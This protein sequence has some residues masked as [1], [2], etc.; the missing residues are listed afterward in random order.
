[1]IDTHG[2]KYVQPLFDIMSKFLAKKGIHPI[3]ITLSALVLGLMSICFVYLDWKVIA[4]FFLWSSGLLD[5]LDGTVARLT[6]RKSDLGAFLDITFDRII[7]LGL[8]IALALSD[9]RLSIMLV[10]LSC[11]IVMSLTIFLTIGNFAKKSTNKA[12]YYQAG[13]AERTEGFIFF[14]LMI[15]FP[16]VRLLIGYIFASVILFTAAQR[17]IEGVNLLKSEEVK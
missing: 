16:S 2:R 5:V 14:S 7:E 1:M 11:S 4:L 15:L 9:D 13:L 8:I 3:H 12:F 17:F 6:D 10:L